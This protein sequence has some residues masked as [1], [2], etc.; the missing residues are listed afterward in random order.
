MYL[1]LFIFLNIDDAC[2]NNPRPKQIIYLDDC[3][4]SCGYSS[5]LLQMMISNCL[6]F[7]ASLKCVVSTSIP[8]DKMN[9]HSLSFVKKNYTKF[10]MMKPIYATLYQKLKSYLKR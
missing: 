9:L 8:F 4:H 1:E 2:S 5:R 3:S 7:T 6:D 10:N